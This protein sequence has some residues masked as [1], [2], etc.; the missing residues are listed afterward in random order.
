M[1]RVSAFMPPEVIKAIWYCDPEAKPEGGIISAFV[2]PVSLPQPSTQSSR[3]GWSTG[4]TRFQSVPHCLQ[5]HVVGWFGPPKALQIA[6]VLV[7][8]TSTTIVKPAGDIRLSPG[9]SLL[10]EW[11]GRG[12]EFLRTKATVSQASSLSVLPSPKH[13]VP[14]RDNKP[15]LTAKLNVVVHS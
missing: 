12:N 8:I 4:R 10:H 6:P 1:E 11:N 2:V 9:E 15:L 13:Q 3:I 5:V 7:H 14:R